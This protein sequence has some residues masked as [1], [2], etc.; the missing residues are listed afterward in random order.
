MTSSRHFQSLFSLTASLGPEVGRVLAGRPGGRAAAI[1]ELELSPDVPRHRAVAEGTI[2][3]GRLAAIGTYA[4]RRRL[5]S[6]RKGGGVVIIGVG[7][8]HG[9]GEGCGGDR[10]LLRPAA[11]VLEI[12][13]GNV[14]ILAAGPGAR[15]LAAARQDGPPLQRGVHGHCNMA[16]N[17]VAKQARKT[18]E[19]LSSE[20]SSL[21]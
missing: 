12:T 16:K 15:P 13:F 19:N 1:M 9:G 21:D 4:H 17:T 11:V 7:L 18:R 2:G 3:G 10:Q 8:L 14:E 5:L 6:W 20:L